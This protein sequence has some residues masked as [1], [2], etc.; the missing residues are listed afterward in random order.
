M[1]SIGCT[2]QVAAMPDMPPNANWSGFGTAG[3]DALAPA[4]LLL[5]IFE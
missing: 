2:T 1:R 4:A 5:A 3:G